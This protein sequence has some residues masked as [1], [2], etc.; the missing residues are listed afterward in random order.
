MASPHFDP[1]SW[2]ILGGEAHELE[3]PLE[4]QYTINLEIP[5]ELAKIVTRSRT[6][7]DVE[8]GEM[9]EEIIHKK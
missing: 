8:E 9:Q 4:E 5:I 6:Q 2:V 7:Q 1:T 3:E